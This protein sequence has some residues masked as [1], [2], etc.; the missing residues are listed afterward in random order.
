MNNTDAMLPPDPELRRQLLAFRWEQQAGGIAVLPQADLLK[1]LGGQSPDRAW[2]FILA[3][4]Y[5]PPPDGLITHEALQRSI[6]RSLQRELQREL[7][8]R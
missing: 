5:E 8:E 2:A 1:R 7:S 6:A 3:V 4:G